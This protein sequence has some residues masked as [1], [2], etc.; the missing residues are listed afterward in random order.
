[1]LTA[2]ALQDVGRDRFV[3]RM[4]ITRYREVARHRKPENLQ[5]RALLLRGIGL[6]GTDEAVTELVQAVGQSDEVEAALHGLGLVGPRAI[7]SLLFVIKTGDPVRTPLAVRALA[8]AG[9][10]ALD[11]L[12]GLLVHP[13]RE[14]RNVARQAVAHIQITEVVP[15]I[16]DL[17]KDASTPGRAQLVALLGA[18]YCD[19]SFSALRSLV[20]NKDDHTMREAAVKV[21]AQMPDPRVYKLLG[22]VAVNDS[23]QDIRLA[24]VKGLIWQGDTGSVPLLIGLLDY[25]KDFIRKVAAQALGYLARPKDVEAIEPNLSTPRNEVIT[26]VRNAM[27]RVT[28]QPRLKNGDDFVEWADGY[29]DPTRSIPELRGGEMTLPDGTTMH[30]W[31]HGAGTPVLVLPDGPDYPHDYLRLAVDRLADDHLIL[32]VDLPGRGQSA[33]PKD[34]GVPMG[35]EHDVQSLATMLARLNLRDI[36]IYG[37]GFGA[38][39]AVR[40]ADKYPKLVSRMVL[41][42]SPQP[43]LGGWQ[44]RVAVAASRVPEPWAHDLEWFRSE[45]PR[46]SPDVRD[47]WLSLALLTGAVSR[48]Q[49]LV[50]VWPLIKTNPHIRRA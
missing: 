36:Q 42:G 48:P 12:M 50:D 38:M 28:F 10:G 5:E 14:V 8:D 37:H 39:V 35:L 33:G 24:A 46:F 21:L 43:T 22:N 11:P 31:L 25:E 49:A 27:K 13:T 40:L 15:N 7:S 1:M 2:H 17:I 34:P 32:Y 45:G 6:S 18:L 16:V 9:T 30:Y 41:D 23:N 26:A 3:E 29:V 19:E 47:R 44:Q 4:L 20:Q